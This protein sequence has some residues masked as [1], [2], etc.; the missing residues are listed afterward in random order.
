MR[1]VR[2][3]LLL[4]LS[5]LLSVAVFIVLLWYPWQQKDVTNDGFK[6]QSAGLQKLNFK[7]RT[8]KK[9]RLLSLKTTPSPKVERKGFSRHHKLRETSKK[10]RNVFNKQQ[11]WREIPIVERNGS[12]SIDGKKGKIRIHVVEEHHEGEL[13]FIQLNMISI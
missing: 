10:E 8:V 3:S 6:R 9:N 5:I 11:N 4:K 12:R 1:M 2:I 7:W 13:C